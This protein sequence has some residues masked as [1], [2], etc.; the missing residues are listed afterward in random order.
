M[1]VGIVGAGGIVH[2]CLQALDEVENVNCSAICTR[3]QEVDVARSLAEKHD[4]RKVYTNY[5]EMLS[6]EDVDIV[7]IGIINNLHYDYA[8]P[9]LEHGKHVICEKPFTST[10]KESKTLESLAKQKGLFLF[11]AITLL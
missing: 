10:L 3:E 8:K 1:K 9:A 6:D 11:E 2:I 7:Y 4:I 5:A